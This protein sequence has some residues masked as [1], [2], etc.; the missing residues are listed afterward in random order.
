MLM[1]IAQ[2]TALLTTLGVTV[3]VAGARSDEETIPVERLPM[4]VRNAIELKFPEARIQRVEEEQEHGRAIYDV[5]LVRNGRDID[6]MLAPDGTILEIERQI[7]P[8]DLPPAVTGA[9][10]THHIEGTVRW[11]EVTTRGKRRH[12][13]LIVA[14]PD[15]SLLDI[16]F[17]ADGTLLDLDRD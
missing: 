7:D 15:Q 9:L 10:M 5:D 6:L 8:A 17:G 4:T 3:A 11:A 1:H 16:E 12:Y 14:T 13:E 2:R